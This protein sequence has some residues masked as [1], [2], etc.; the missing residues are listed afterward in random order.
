MAGRYVIIYAAG[1]ASMLAGASVVHAI[2]KP[3]L[4]LPE[5]P[6]PDIGGAGGKVTPVAEASATAATTSVPAVSTDDAAGAA[7]VVRPRP[8]RAQ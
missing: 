8:P 5:V 1:L 7:P 4:T 2:M 6:T 3:D